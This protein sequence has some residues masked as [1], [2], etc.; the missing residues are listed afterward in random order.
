ML[1]KIKNSPKNFWG[2]FALSLLLN[3][4]FIPNLHAAPT[5]LD[6]S[7]G[8]GGVAQISF[9]QP[10]SQASS[11]VIEG[12]KLVL[13]GYSQNTALAT[14]SSKVAIT[15]LNLS[16]GSLDTSFGT[17]GKVETPFPGGAAQISKVA[18]TPT[19]KIVAAGTFYPTGGSGGNVALIRYNSN[20]ALDSSF[21]SDGIV[22]ANFAGTASSEQVNGMAIQGT[23]GDGDIVVAGEANGPPLVVFSSR[24]TIIGNPDSSDTPYGTTPSIG[25]S[26][27]C[28]TTGTTPTSKGNAIA[29]RSSDQAV[30]IAG[31]VQGT[32]NSEML[33][34][35][36]DQNG[37]PASAGS[38]E[39]RIPFAGKDA[40]ARAVALQTDGKILVAGT[41]LALSGGV[42]NSSFNLVRL[43][44]D[45]T[46]DPTFGTA[47]KVETPF[48]KALSMP[49]SIALSDSKVLVA[50]FT[51]GGTPATASIAVARYN[52]NG[53]LDST[54][55]TGGKFETNVGVNSG[56]S[57]ITVQSDGKILVGGATATAAD[58][59]DGKMFA[60]RLMG[61]VASPAGSPPGGGGSGGG[62][63]GCNFSSFASTSPWL[64]AFWV[65]GLMGLGLLRRRK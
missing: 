8:T 41:A 47:G 28:C 26:F 54:F 37:R 31:Q 35:Q 40:E 55:G 11:M 58:F 61:P 39:Y 10:A 4:S 49:T 38:G 32:T 12:D 62:G 46:P 36:Y 63:G 15:R 3:V 9:S 27:S 18:L 24:Y 52:S 14:A 7:F 53:T 13:G 5:D 21:G 17:A 23:S 50:G 22:T 29:I 20:G 43:N 65:I 57:S 44:A 48:S 19:G 51:M 56:A 33:V 30:F 59:S 64:N 16:N 42:I 60:L 34:L 1:Q 2:I 6:P 45:G 25:A